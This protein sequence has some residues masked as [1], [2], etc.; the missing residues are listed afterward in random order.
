MVVRGWQLVAG[1]REQPTRFFLFPNALSRRSLPLS[2]TDKRG[3]CRVARVSMN[4]FLSKNVHPDPA[5]NG[6]VF[7]SIHSSR[8]EKESSHGYTS[9]PIRTFLQRRSRCF[10][11][12]WS[13][14]SRCCYVA[15]RRSGTRAN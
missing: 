1:E 11:L 3:N 10:C 9:H 14:W 5:P 2:V 15:W 6:V 12:M 13:G 8:L 4:V 7:I